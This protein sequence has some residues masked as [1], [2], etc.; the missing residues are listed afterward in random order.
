MRQTGYVRRLSIVQAE[1]NRIDT[2]GLL[3]SGAPEDEFVG[4]ACAISRMISEASTVHDIAEAIA[5]VLNRAFDLHNNPSVYHESAQRIHC[6]LNNKEAPD[7][8]PCD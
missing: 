8:Q 5:E 3:D 4:E 7:A 2:Y 1:L 6:T